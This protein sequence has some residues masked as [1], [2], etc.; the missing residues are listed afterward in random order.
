MERGKRYKKRRWKIGKYGEEE[1]KE[2]ENEEE[3]GV[4]RKK[5]NRKAGKDGN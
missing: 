3:H 1:E 2:E 5:K 4:R